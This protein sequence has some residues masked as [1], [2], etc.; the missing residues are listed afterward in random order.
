MDQL[1]FGIRPVIEALNSG[2][3]IERIFVQKGLQGE[4][5]QSLLQLLKQ[6]RISYQL[7]PIEKL[8]RVTRKNHQGVVCLMSPI[9]YSTV[10]DVLPFV[11]EKGETPFILIL[12]GITD[13]RNFGAITRTAE[14]AGVHAIVI[15]EKGGA[16]INSD[17]IKTSAGA[18][19]KIPICR[20]QSLVK[21]IEFLKSSGLKIVACTE[22]GN[23]EIH[24]LKYNDPV[25]LVMGSEKDGISDACLR[26]ADEIASI[27]IKGEIGSLNVSVATGIAL[28]EVLRQ[29]DQ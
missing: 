12:D 7:V 29:R 24:Y 11:Y 23:K 3:E 14:C 5:A 21:A 4:N 18:L 16:Q 1:I 27:P 2:K 19:H 13:V 26:I 17:A 25:A 20:V 22:K 6:R 28:Y 10:E 15:P 8:N 9:T